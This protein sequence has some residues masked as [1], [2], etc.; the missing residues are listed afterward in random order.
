MVYLSVPTQQA[1]AQVRELTLAPYTYETF[2][3][4]VGERITKH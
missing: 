1:T 2:G 3:N 4:I